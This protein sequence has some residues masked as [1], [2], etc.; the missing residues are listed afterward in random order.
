MAI[1]DALFDGYLSSSSNLM[2]HNTRLVLDWWLEPPSTDASSNLK[3]WTAFPASGESQALSDHHDQAV[4][5]DNIATLNSQA[6][7]HD[8]VQY[9]GGRSD[10]EHDL[11][12][13]PVLPASEAA[14]PLNEPSVSQ[15][16]AVGSRS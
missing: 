7:N 1:C 2:A 10:D 12:T 9:S 4:P 14:P 3:Q 16:I 11:L 5:A 8:D 15:T 6:D 13:D